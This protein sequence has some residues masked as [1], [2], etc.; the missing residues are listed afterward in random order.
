MNI[1]AGK[2][3]REFWRHLHCFDQ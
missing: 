2:R 3:E 1:T